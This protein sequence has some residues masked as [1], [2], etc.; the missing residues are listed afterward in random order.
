MDFCINFFFCSKI[1][2]GLEDKGIKQ[3]LSKLKKQTVSIH[4]DILKNDDELK[5]IRIGIEKNKQKKIIF[6]RYI[7]DK[8]DTSRRLFFLLQD[9]IYISP[10]N[11]FIKNL[12]SESE[13][14]ISQSLERIFVLK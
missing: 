12:T 1:A 3:K 9:K 7:K 13:N 6:E 11:K 4:N 14:L 8:E 2:F 5:K 10:I